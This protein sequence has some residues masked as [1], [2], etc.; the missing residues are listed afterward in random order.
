MP[1][2][3]NARTTAVGDPL[4][5]R[6]GSSGAGPGLEPLADEPASRLLTIGHRRQD[7]RSS[8]SLGA[9]VERNLHD[10]ELANHAVA[11]VMGNDCLHVM[12]EQEARHASV[13]SRRT[14]LVVAGTPVN[15]ELLP[16][17]NL[18]LGNLGDCEAVRLA[19]T[20]VDRSVG[21]DWDAYDHT[22]RVLPVRSNAGRGSGIDTENRSHVC[23]AA[24]RT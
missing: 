4:F 7:R 21:Q 1:I 17:S 19:P 16:R 10:A 18:T 3:S 13:V 8:I 12:I 20:R 15:L 6:T 24:V 22:F 11:H 14:A 2:P 5:N 9:E 23:P